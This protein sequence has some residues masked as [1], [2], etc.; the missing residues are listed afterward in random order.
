MVRLPPNSLPSAPKWQSSQ[1][2]QSQSPHNP[3]LLPPIHNRRKHLR[4]LPRRSAI[5]PRYHNTSRNRRLHHRFGDDVRR[6]GGAQCIYDLDDHIQAHLGRTTHGWD[7][8]TRNLKVLQSDYRPRRI[9]RTH[10]NMVERL[11]RTET[12]WMGERLRAF[13]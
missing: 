9:G 8:P 11:R 3:L 6:G 4:P 13:I 7:L 12:V 2:S 5:H 1:G 10:R